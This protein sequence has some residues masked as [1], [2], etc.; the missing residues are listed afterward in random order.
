[1][2]K[3]NLGL[4]VED[5]DA[6][7]EIIRKIYNDVVDRIH[8]VIDF[9]VFF[10]RIG[11]IDN[12]MRCGFFNASNLTDFNGSLICYN[13]DAL[14]MAIEV[15]NNIKL[16]SLCDKLDVLTY[17]K[18]ESKQL[19]NQY[20]VFND[21]QKSNFYRTTGKKVPVYQNNIIELIRGISHE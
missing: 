16:Y 15:V 3:L 5:L 1:M 19:K 10:K 17:F 11:K 7:K 6:D 20:I 14:G 8:D 12:D 4:F 13:L 9:S 18:I 21:L 2:S